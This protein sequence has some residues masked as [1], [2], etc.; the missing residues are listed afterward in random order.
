MTIGSNVLIN[1]I[2]GLTHW[3]R[4]KKA[5]IFADNIFICISLNENFWISNEISLKYIP[6]GL[7][8]NKPSLVQLMYCRQTGNKPLSKPMMV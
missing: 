7:I 2:D 5:A 1:R 4:N 8:V 6:Y 3:G